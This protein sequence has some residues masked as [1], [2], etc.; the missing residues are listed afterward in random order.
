MRRI[1]D[2][3]EAEGIFPKDAYDSPE[4]GQ[5]RSEV[6]VHEKS[7]DL[8]T[9]TD[10][11]RLL[12]VYADA[13]REFGQAYTG[14][15]S[16]DAKALIES[17]KRDGAQVDEHGN[18]VIPPD[19]TP[20]VTITL[21]DYPRLSNPA[22]VSEH[23]D[24]IN[25]S[26]T[27]DPALAIGSCKE[28]VEST[29]KFILDDYNIEYGTKDDLLSLYKKTATALK[30]NAEAVP[31]SA[32]GSQSAQKALRSMATSVQSLAELRNELGLGHGRTAPSPA[33]ARHAKLALQLTRG[34]VGFLL[35]TWHVRHE[36]K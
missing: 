10:N 8:S 7:L 31:G 29:C 2:L 24:R 35:D 20:T 14:G 17:L 23:L 16:S 4:S 18:I 15:L 12:R 1:A 27:S 32:K 11:H 30:L 19:P 34:L 6:D 33:L 9:D 26:I 21:E 5:R 13:I 28:L 3:F 36:A 25:A 22:V